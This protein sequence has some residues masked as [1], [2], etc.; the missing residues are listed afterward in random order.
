MFGHLLSCPCVL[1]GQS[2]VNSQPGVKRITISHPRSPA[3]NKILEH[4]ERSSIGRGD[5]YMAEHVRITMHGPL[6]LDKSPCHPVDGWKIMLPR[7]RQLS[8]KK[9]PGRSR[10]G[11][12]GHM[13]TSLF[14]RVTKP[15]IGWRKIELSTTSRLLVK[16]DETRVSSMR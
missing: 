13:G 1:C 8:P 4:G 14:H 3:K 7:V 15:S 16:P 9:E 11:F 6:Y 5:S 12:P 10:T 2:V